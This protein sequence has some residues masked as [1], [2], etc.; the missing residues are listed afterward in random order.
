MNSILS[1]I[2]ELKTN[3]EEV[4]T[5]LP[6]SEFGNDK[7]F[8]F[9][10][11]LPCNLN[12]KAIELSLSEPDHLHLSEILLLRNGEWVDIR[13]IEGLC[14][15]QSSVHYEGVLACSV[16]NWVNRLNADFFCTEFQKSPF[17]KF[18]LPKDLPIEGI[19][20]G[21]RTDGLWR[22]AKTLKVVILNSDDKAI[23][24][25]DGKNIVCR[26]ERLVKTI[27]NCHSQLSYLEA[28]SESDIVGG[29]DIIKLLLNASSDLATS[30]LSDAYQKIMRLAL[31][32]FFDFYLKE[33]EKGNKLIL[34]FDCE[35]LFKLGTL[36]EIKQSEVLVF[37]SVLFLLVNGANQQAFN[38]IKRI[39]KEG[40]TLDTLRLEKLTKQIGLQ[41]FGYP[42]ILTA[43]TFQR[44]LNTYEIDLVNFIRSALD[45]LREIPNTSSMIC[46][47]TLLGAIREGDFI[48]HDDDID[49]LLVITKDHVNLENIVKDTVQLFKENGFVVDLKY[50]FDEAA[51]PFLEIKDYRYPVH[52]DVFIGIHESP[53][54]FMPMKSVKNEF[55]DESMLLPVRYLESGKFSG[56]PVTA[57]PEGFLE[58]RYG[59][60]WRKPDPMFR[61]NEN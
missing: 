8:G 23:T 13:T 34:Q 27:A 49:L 53:K 21:N 10:I 24:L 31:E 59:K 19:S 41:C 7:S 26:I 42:L 14:T 43:H 25:W 61:L 56:L 16:E 33:I 22:R 11:E 15:E 45:V 44:P 5:N 28:V 9:N 30:P 39:L 4:K 60:G 2:E 32:R 52:L 6:H 3:S 17:V 18:C 50:T 1:P 36:L 12:M 37:S 58:V 20:I 35:S 57:N 38:F 47:G 55:V 54:I 48:A 29:N 46:Y 40:T 51:L